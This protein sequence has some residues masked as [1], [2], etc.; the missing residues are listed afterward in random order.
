MLHK[1]VGDKRSLAFRVIRLVIADLFALSK[2][3]RGVERFGHPPLIALNYLVGRFQDRLSRS[4]VLFEFYYL[5]PHEVVLKPE[6]DIEI[7]SSERINALVDITNH[8]QAS[9]LPEI[10]W[11]PLDLC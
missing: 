9:A 11:R 4:I 3:R 6:D 7:G 1:P 8:A 5:C 10:H 2:F